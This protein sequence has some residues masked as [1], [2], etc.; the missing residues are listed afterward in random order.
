M[1]FPFVPSP[2]PSERPGSVHRR[3]SARLKGKKISK[4]AVEEAVDT[5]KRTLF[6]DDDD[7]GTLIESGIIR[8]ILMEL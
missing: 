4:T 5:T 3:E 6:A 8:C 2:A 7:E 1:D